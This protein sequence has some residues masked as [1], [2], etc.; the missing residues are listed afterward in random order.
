MPGFEEQGFIWKTLKLM[1]YEK[2]LSTVIKLSLC[3]HSM[4]P[5]LLLDL[6]L[7]L[8]FYLAHVIVFTM[9]LYHYTMLKV[10]PEEKLPDPICKAH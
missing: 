6:S 2:R 9:D 4:H 3:G 7:L 5:Q 1:F 10:N 8:V